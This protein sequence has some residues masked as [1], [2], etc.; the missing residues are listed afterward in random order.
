MIR[1]IAKSIN[2]IEKDF[3]N[4][5]KNVKIIEKSVK[6]IE[7]LSK[8]VYWPKKRF[9]RFA[10]QLLNHTVCILGRVDY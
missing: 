6:N 1:N 8:N 7:K 10:V 3:K 2:N 5:E 9:L 4:T